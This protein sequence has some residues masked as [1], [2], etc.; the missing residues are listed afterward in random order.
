MRFRKWAKKLAVSGLTLSILAGLVPYWTNQAKATTPQDFEVRYGKAAAVIGNETFE[1]SNAF[2]NF[3]GNATSDDDKERAYDSVINQS[4]KG[5]AQTK[6]SGTAKYDWTGGD[7]LLGID[8][9]ETLVKFEI[10]IADNPELKAIALSGHAKMEVGFNV[11]RHHSGFSWDRK[12]SIKIIVDD[13]VVLFAWASDANIYNQ[14]ETVLIKPNS[15]IKI[16]AFGEGDDDG[17]AAGALGFFIKFKDDQRPVL[18]GYSFTGNGAERTNPNTS[19]EELYVKQEENISMQY[20]FTEPVKPTALNSSYN[21]HFLKHP[22]FVNPDGTGLPASGQNQYLIN[23]TYDSSNIDEYKDNVTFEYTGVKY[24]NSGNLPLGPKIDQ[25]SDGA[26]PMDK[27]LNQKMTEAIFA[28]AAGNIADMSNIMKATD[29]SNPYLRGKT[30]DP[31]NYNAGGYRVIV[32]AVAPKYTKGANGIQPDIMTGAVVNNNDV[33][34][35][36]L[37][38]TEEAVVKKGYDIDKTYILFNNGMKAYYVSGKNQKNWT[39]RL[40]ITEKVNIENPLLKVLAI[41]NDD[42]GDGT[43]KDV[44]QDYAGNLLIQPANYNGEHVDG[45]ISLVNSKIDWAALTIDNTKPEIGFSYESGGANKTTYLKSGKVIINANDPQLKVPDLDPIVEDRGIYK[46]SKGIYR[47]SNMTG[48]ASPSVGLVYY[49][50][51]QSP[52][53]PFLADSAD[54]FAAIKRYSLSAKQ[55]AQELYPD[56]YANTT[57]QVSNNKTNL[58]APPA[59]ALTEAKSGEWYLHAWTSDMT[60]D[61]ARE[62]MQYNKKKTYVQGHLEQYAAWKAETNGSDADK[63]FYADNKAMAAVGQYGDTSVWQLSDFKQDDSNWSYSSTLIKLDNKKPAIVFQ[64]PAGDNSFNVSVT[65]NVSDEHSGLKETSYQWVKNGSQPKEIDWKAVTLVNGANTFLSKN[66]VFED[67]KYLLYIKAT[68]FAGNE[69]ITKTA[70]LTVNS[71]TRVSGSFSP[72]PD[73]HYVQSHDIIFKFTGVNPS[74]VAYAFNT[75]SV[76]PAL[77]TAYTAVSAAAGG[78]DN[79]GRNFTVPVGTSK[80]GPVYV[81]MLVKE[82]TNIYYYYSKEYFFDNTAPVISFSKNG[83]AYPQDSHELIATVTETYSTV[84][85]VNMYQWIKDGQAAPTANSSGWNALL[86]GGAVKIDGSAQQIGEIVDYKLFVWAKDGAGNSLISSPANSFKVSK[87]GV[88]LP[89][90]NAKSDLIYLYGDQNDSYTAII[91]L[92]LDSVDKR[93]YEYSISPDD[94]LSWVKWRAF[95]N[96]VSLSVPTGN[97]ADLKVKVKYRTPGGAIGNAVA[98]NIGTNI[99]EEPIYAI[100]GLRQTGPVN[101]AIGADIDIILPSSDIR[102]VPSTVNPSVPLRSVNSFNVKVNGF[103]SFDISSLSDPTRKDTLFLIVNSVDGT[104]PTAEFEYIGTAPTNGNV[105]ARL[106]ASEPVVVTN[107]A[108]HS[109]YTFTNNGTFTFEFKDEAGNIGTAT[110]TVNNID[111]SGP[112]VKIVRSYV[113]GDSGEKAYSTLLDNN[114]DVELSSGVVLEVQ[115]LTDSAKSFHVIEGAKKVAMQENGTATFTVADDIGNTLKIT[116]EVVNV[117]SKPPEAAVTYTFIDENGNTLPDNKLISIAGKTYAK[118][119]VKATFSGNT[120]PK[121]RIFWGVVPIKDEQDAF[122]NLISNQAGEFTYSRVFSANGTTTIALADELNNVNKVPVTIIGLD[123]TPPELAL[124]RTSVGVAQNKTNFDFRKDL[125]GFAVTDN[126]SAA[127]NIKV[128]ISGLNLAQ[129]GK[130]RVTYTAEDQVGNQTIAY[131]DVVVVSGAGMLIFGNDV[132][133]SGSSGESA[134]F[135]GNTVTFNVDQFNK[136]NVN[137]VKTINEKGTFDLMYQ[138]GLYREGQMKYIAKKVTYQ[139][140]IDGQ[141]KITFPQAGWYT[142]IVRNQEREREFATFFITRMEQSNGQEALK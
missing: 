137:G 127:A 78:D 52:T 103:Y 48:S 128:S 62:V 50:W 112:Q 86:P 9:E 125:G 3:F 75:S 54:Q 131:Q 37:Q 80:N 41:S 79:N 113:Y 77:E 135:E 105:T 96:F 5:F 1:A 63:T 73:T 92:A 91:K 122:T 72:A 57:I 115:K 35:F 25:A 81:H 97:A 17:V 65:A 111:K 19:Q 13:Q 114:G 130:Q 45:D 11:L 40:P 31:F 14:K 20:Q 107:N 34:D 136:V 68:D 93:G 49:V 44:I 27:N 119:K 29:S 59:E 32:D 139:Q 33:V 30:V 15:V 94:G 90:E 141:Y 23:Q 82:G 76:R 118:G 123:N 95:T 2:Q 71:E 4:M 121:N 8:D 24:H 53:D 126:L 70:A 64:A 74:K 98:L 16:E 117:M 100:A 88:G 85:S 58:I 134:L 26:S 18:N 42:K 56:K 36:I 66:D 138:T 47:P 61:T 102:I 109:T 55:P 106:I 87:S 104:A 120:N 12:S 43:D 39:F 124:L 108:G 38:L 133:I 140:L 46:P 84:G 7:L 132:L 67:G 110:A 99:T 142:I 129:L 116:E 83:S 6:T 51:S 101:A 28:D 21:S 89:A 69:N 10:H 22:L 60:W